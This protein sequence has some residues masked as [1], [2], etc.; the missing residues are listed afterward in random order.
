MFLSLCFLWICCYWKRPE[1]LFSAGLLDEARCLSSNLHPSCGRIILPLMISLSDGEVVLECSMSGNCWSFVM[2]QLI[3]PLIGGD[4]LVCFIHLQPS[5][6]YFQTSPTVLL[7]LCYWPLCEL[8]CLTSVGSN[9]VWGNIKQFS[10]SAQRFTAED[11]FMKQ[12]KRF[13]QLLNGE[14][15]HAVCSDWLNHFWGF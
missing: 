13:H 2:G 10:T 9:R 5:T 3:E 4:M 7:P 8:F 11:P 12:R 15:R 14:F 6:I 1:G